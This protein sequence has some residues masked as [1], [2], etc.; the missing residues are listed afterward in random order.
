MAVPAD[1]ADARVKSIALIPRTA[2]SVSLLQKKHNLIPSEEI[3]RAE[4]TRSLMEAG[5][6]GGCREEKECHTYCNDPAHFAECSSFGAR[7]DH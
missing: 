1:A 5:G 6:P 3:E 2:M 4:N 7:G